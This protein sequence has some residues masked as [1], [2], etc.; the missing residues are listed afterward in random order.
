LEFANIR[1]YRNKTICYALG[2]LDIY[3]D[4]PLLSLPQKTRLKES[5]PRPQPREP[6]LRKTPQPLKEP[7]TPGN[8]QPPKDP[9]PLMLPLIDNYIPLPLEQCSDR[10]EG[11]PIADVHSTND[12]ENSSVVSHGALN[13]RRDKAPLLPGVPFTFQVTEHHSMGHRKRHV[14]IDGIEIYLQKREG[15][16]M[17]TVDRGVVKTIRREHIVEHMVNNPQGEYF[18]VSADY[19]QRF[20]QNQY[21]ARK[22]IEACES[23]A[24]S[25]KRKRDEL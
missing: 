1:L 8:P 17:T 18:I 5:Q 14:T 16:V 6:Q 9:N 11:S 15:W 3:L 12:V 10:S 23:E 2:C 19:I 4:R 22:I 20:I 13:S 21:K 24:G 7:E 25:R